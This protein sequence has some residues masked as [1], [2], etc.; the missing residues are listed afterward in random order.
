MTPLSKWMRWTLLATTVY[1]AFGVLLFIPLLSLGRELVGL[2]GAHPFYLWLVTIWIGSFGV[3]YLWVAVIGRS[4]PAFLI[5]A[6]VGK[7]S[8]FSLMFIFWLAGDFPGTAPL[9]ATGDLI[10]AILFTAWLWKTR[11]SFC[12]PLRDSN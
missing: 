3:L 7:F 1:N 11:R 12:G 5:I 6:A 10:T 4:D 8:F 2:P 9:V